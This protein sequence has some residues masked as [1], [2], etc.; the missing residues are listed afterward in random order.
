[1]KYS[2]LEHVEGESSEQTLSSEAPDE[3]C[4]QMQE[5]KRGGW[6]AFPYI[7]G[8]HNSEL[9]YCTVSLANGLVDMY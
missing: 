8:I 6:K 4:M 7:I 9:T 3:G 5:S 1:M 2:E